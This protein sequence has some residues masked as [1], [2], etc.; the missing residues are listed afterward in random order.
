MDYEDAGK[1]GAGKI[2]LFS[3]KF[4]IQNVKI[5][6]VSMETCVWLPLSQFVIGGFFQ[7]DSHQLG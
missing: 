1:R 5:A 6:V 2:K 3:V 4:K 7:G